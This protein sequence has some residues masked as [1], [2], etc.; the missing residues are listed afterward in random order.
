[1]KLYYQWPRLAPRTKS[2]LGTLTF[3]EWS[4]KYVV[5]ENRTKSKCPW[6]HKVGYLES[7]KTAPALQ[8]FLF[9]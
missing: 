2:T 5:G 9:M 7:S 6:A 3:V 4:S 1:M 8:A